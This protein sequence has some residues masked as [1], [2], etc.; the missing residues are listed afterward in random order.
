[1]HRVKELETAEVLSRA[2]GKPQKRRLVILQREDG[3]FS[4]AE[5]YSYVSEYE[6]EV[7]AKGWQQLLPNGVYD[8]IE[9]AEAE[10][11]AAAAKWHART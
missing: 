10:G 9:T 11:R 7:I 5:E 2:T 1:M 3:H 6:G 8:S 4:L